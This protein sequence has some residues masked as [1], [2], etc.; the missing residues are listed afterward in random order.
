[1]DILVVDDA[2]AT[3]DLLSSWLKEAGYSVRA[4]ISGELAI[5]SAFDF[6]PALVILDVRMQGIDGFEVCRRLRLHPATSEV[7]VI[8]VSGLTD[9]ANRMRG[10]EVG[11]VDFIT[12]PLRREE[13][14]ARVHAQMRLCAAMDVLNRTNRDLE[15]TVRQRT[16]DLLKERNTAQNYLDI[17]SVA[18]FAMDCD[19]NLFGVIS[20]SVQIV[21]VR[22]KGLPFVSMATMDNVASQSSHQWRKLT[23]L[24]LRPQFVRATYIPRL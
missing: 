12:K 24:K 13:V 2:P 8:F 16:A 20:V 18:L 9:I 6:P 22:C 14:L 21:T 19:G 3:L 11:G 7:P 17:A 10:F 5:R 4:A 15:S 23:G 1:M